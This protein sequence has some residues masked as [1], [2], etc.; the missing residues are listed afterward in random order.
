[1]VA[2]LATPIIVMASA[3]GRRGW[4]RIFGD[5]EAKASEQPL[6]AWNDLVYAVVVT[7]AMFACVLLSYASVTRVFDIDDAAHWTAGYS[8]AVW[9]CYIL[10][11]TAIGFLAQA[12]L[13]AGKQLGTGIDTRE[14]TL[15]R[16]RMFMSTL[17]IKLALLALFFGWALLVSPGK[18]LAP[19]AYG[20]L[21]LFVTDVLGAIVV[22]TVD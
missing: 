6:L 22:M 15:K 8:L 3:V 14:N 5:K 21:V 12:I 9:L 4:E 2:L 18:G 1:M 11:S 19:T 20:L 7:V 16:R 17:W 13:S 10:L